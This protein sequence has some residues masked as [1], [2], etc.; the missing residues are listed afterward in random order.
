MIGRNNMM[1]YISED[2]HFLV[3]GKNSESD[4]DNNTYDI[5]FFSGQLVFYQMVNIR[6][7]IYTLIMIKFR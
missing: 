2:M 3:T 4:E 5:T 1:N 7:L 6:M